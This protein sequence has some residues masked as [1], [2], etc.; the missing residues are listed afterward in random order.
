MFMGSGSVEEAKFP[1]IK[2]SQL[3]SADSVAGM[4]EQ[5]LRW[6]QDR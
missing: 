4:V 5:G 6:A 1:T 3:D 2:E